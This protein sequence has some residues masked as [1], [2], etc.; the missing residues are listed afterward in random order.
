ME[1]ALERWCVDQDYTSSCLL[2]EAVVVILG[3]FSD[4]ILHVNADLVIGVC[5]QVREQLIAL[6]PDAFDE[7]LSV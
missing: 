4:L 3:R 2:V 7:A 5:L 1:L 6:F